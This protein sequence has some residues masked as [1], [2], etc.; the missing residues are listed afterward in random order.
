L[1]AAERGRRAVGEQGDTSVAD[2]EAD[3]KAEM[4]APWPGNG[5]RLTW[6]RFEMPHDGAAESA[7]DVRLLVEQTFRP[8]SYGVAAAGRDLQDGWMQWHVVAAVRET[9]DGRRTNELREEFVR[10]L[11]GTRG[12]GLFLGRNAESVSLACLEEL[13]TYDSLFVIG[14]VSELRAE[15]D[16]PVQRSAADGEGVSSLG[17]AYERR[18]RAQFGLGLDVSQVQR[19]QEGKAVIVER[20]VTPNGEELWSIRQGSGDVGRIT[21]VPYLGGGR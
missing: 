1:C 14:S 12:P 20:V 7:D 5:S 16:L 21:M 6:F 19:E 2:A 18:T 15:L 8:E 3:N 4:F 13:Q 11:G 17:E 9:I 10:Q